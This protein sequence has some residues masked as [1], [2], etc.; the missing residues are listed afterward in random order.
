MYSMHRLVRRFIIIDMERG[1]KLWNELYSVALLTVREA[2]ETELK[3]EDKSFEEMPNV[4]GNKHHEISVHAFGLVE[5]HT[6]PAQ[7]IEVQHVSEI[8]DIHQYCGNVM[9]FVG[10]SE[11]GVQ[12]WEHLLEILQHQQ[13]ANRSRNFFGRLPNMWRDESR[14]EEEKS[15][16][17]DVYNL[18][19]LAL[20][21]DGRFNDA[22]SKHELS[23]E[24]RLA[25]HGPN[26]SHPDIA[27]SLNN[28][29]S[30]YEGMGKLEKA[31][32]KYDE[33][34]EMKLEIHGHDR[35]H[36]AIATSLNNLGNVHY[37]MGEQ[38]K[39]LEHHEQ[40]L[41]MFRAI[42]GDDRPH[43]AIANSLG[44]I[45]NVCQRLGTLD[46][47]LEKHRQSLEMYLAI[48]GHSKPHP[49][50]ATS[51]SNLGTVY[52]RLGDFDKALQMY[53]ESLKME[54]RSMDLTSR[55]L[56]LHLHLVTLG[57]C[58]NYWVSW[59]ERWRSTNRV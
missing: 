56:T 47:A 35:P 14:E 48:H 2:V 37:Q 21:R 44:N 10:R 31:L 26:K 27:T 49:D 12:V 24:M 29:G 55:T 34:L 50:I 41:E 36:L 38:K 11:E 6:L 7:G 57:V 51:L 54:Q 33:S 52:Q 45:G 53:E 20:G 19:G 9:E 22:A 30:A 59:T 32:Q 28:L 5:H 1:S 13:V 23:L 25:I 46:K 42:Y 4:F 43:L 58:I 15:R 17:A 8:E 3:K 18:L 40:G 39:A 16:F